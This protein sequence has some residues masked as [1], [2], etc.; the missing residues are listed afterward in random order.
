MSWTLFRG[1]VQDFALNPMMALRLPKQSLSTAWTNAHC[2][3]SFTLPFNS[4]V[5]YVSVYAPVLTKYSD[6]DRT[7]VHGSGR[8]TPSSVTRSCTST[9][10][11]TTFRSSLDHGYGLVYTSFLDAY[12]TPQMIRT[13]MKSSLIKAFPL[14]GLMVLHQS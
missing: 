13:L 6:D 1:F 12:T 9:K 11:A 10:A 2:L 5:L 7:L 3:Q 8:A 4:T 14:V